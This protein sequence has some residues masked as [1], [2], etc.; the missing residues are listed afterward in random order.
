MAIQIFRARLTLCH[1]VRRQTSDSI[2]IYCCQ[3]VAFVA[4]GDILRKRSDFYR[5]PKPALQSWSR[6]HQGMRKA[7]L[8]TLQLDPPLFLFSHN[9]YYIT[10]GGSN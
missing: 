8:L 2:R 7:S 4:S 9:C 6:D 10:F 1:R 5:G 3:Q